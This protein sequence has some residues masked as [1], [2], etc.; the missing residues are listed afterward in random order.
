MVH[1]GEKKNVYKVLVEEPEGKIP[2]AK[3]TLR[4]E[5]TT[6]VALEET[7]GEG[8]DSVTQKRTRLL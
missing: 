3:S 5:P 4:L 1:K 8:T 2:P 6:E 7:G